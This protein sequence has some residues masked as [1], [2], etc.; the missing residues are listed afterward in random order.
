MGRIGFFLRQANGSAADDDEI[1]DRDRLAHELMYLARGNPVIYYGDEQGFVGDGGDQDA[2]Q[3]MFPSQVATYNNDDLIATDATTAD[4]NFDTT[5]PLYKAI[6][7]LAALTKEHPALRNGPQQSRYSTEGAG[8]YAFSRL[9]RA[10]GR[11]YVV[12]LNNSEQEQTAFIP[13]SAGRHAAFSRVYGD[14]AAAATTDAGR[15]LGVTVPPLSTVVYRSSAAIPLSAAAPE[16]AV[17]PLPDGG[18]ARDRAEVR[19]FVDGSSFY[20]VT[21]QAKV[22]DGEWTTI[23]TDDNEPYRVFHEVAGIAPGTTVQY[24]ATVLDNAGHTRTS[25]PGQLQVAEPSVT[26]T[27]PPQDGRVRERARLTAEVTP[28][29]ND[30]S[31]RFERSVDG[32]AWTAVG[33]D[34]SQ[35]VYTLS[36][37]VSGLDP[38]TAIEYRAVLTYAAGHT[39]TSAS[40]SVTVVEPVTTAT[41]HDQRSSGV[42]H[43]IEIADDTK[44]VGFVVHGKP[45]GGTPD[46]K[47][48]TN[49]PD[50]FFTPIDHPEIWLEQGDPVIYFSP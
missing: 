4:S 23:G 39:V 13:T 46:T 11:E 25:D 35:P 8:I 40:R 6:G 29:D 5:H 9:D 43:E 31:V 38:G 32:G 33:S 1:F 48:P 26:L 10:G 2:R 12:A 22:G 42:F 44:Q 18:E 36:D 3:D 28:D 47:D 50:R 45:P 30:N 21:F 14:G 17:A 24:R 15:R 41:I 34:S 49:S 27:A 20:D 19:A 16:I 7:R 37:D